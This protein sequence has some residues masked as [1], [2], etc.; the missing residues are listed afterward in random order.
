ML[1]SSKTKELYGLQKR[2]IALELTS[3]ID[4]TSDVQKEIEE[5]ENTLLLE[6]K[7]L[8]FTGPESFE[9]KVD[10]Q[11]NDLLILIT[12]HTSIDA[13]KLTVFE[14]YNALEFIDKTYANNPNSI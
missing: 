11:F 8:V 14:F 4:E 12:K 1:E 2:R 5:I 9:V 6:S 13:K 10:K 3:L 7:P